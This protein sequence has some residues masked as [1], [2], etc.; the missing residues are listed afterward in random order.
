MKLVFRVMAFVIALAPLSAMADETIA[1]TISGLRYDG[2]ADYTYFTGPASWR[3]TGCNPQ[4]VEVTATVAQRQKLLAVALAAYA[5]GKQV[6]FQGTC[7]S[8]TNY[9]DATYISVIG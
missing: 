6:Q 4:F 3:A 9:F 2:V 1:Q 5:A 7:N 8:N